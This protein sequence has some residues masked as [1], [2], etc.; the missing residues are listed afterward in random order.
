MLTKIRGLC[1]AKL[2]TA[3]V[4]IKL[5]FQDLTSHN[6]QCTIL[7][8]FYFPCDNTQI[9]IKYYRKKKGKG[10]SKCPLEP[11]SWFLKSFVLNVSIILAN[12]HACKYIRKF[13]PTYY[14]YQKVVY[15]H[16]CNCFS[17]LWKCWEVPM[18]F[19]T[20]KILYVFIISPIICK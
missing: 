17:F 19:N 14:G 20:Y 4:L 15:W 2:N 1:K 16:I 9:P 12:N 5:S 13:T 11:T 7:L 10:K 8:P 18:T 3:S 6:N